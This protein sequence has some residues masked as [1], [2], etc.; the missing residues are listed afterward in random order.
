MI[1]DLCI[2]SRNSN[3]ITGSKAQFNPNEARGL[4]AVSVDWEKLTTGMCSDRLQKARDI[5][6]EIVS[7]CG[8]ILCTTALAEDGE[9]VKSSEV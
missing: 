4:K 8:A 3:I 2:V 6:G 7:V 5:I 1:H 9:H